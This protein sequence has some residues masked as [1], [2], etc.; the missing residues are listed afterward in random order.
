MRGGSGTSAD[1]DWGCRWDK[2]LQG[3]KYFLGALA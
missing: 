1:V 3:G 2:S